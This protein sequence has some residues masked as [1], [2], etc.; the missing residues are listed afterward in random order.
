MVLDKQQT[1]LKTEPE[2]PPEPAVVVW[3]TESP[4]ES[5]LAFND[6]DDID[7]DIKDHILCEPEIDADN[8]RNFSESSNCSEHQEFGDA[9]ADEFLM[10]EK[11]KQTK[12]K[13]RQ[14]ANKVELPATS[15]RASRARSRELRRNAANA[16]PEEELVTIK[17]IPATTTATK[18]TF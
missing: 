12:G 14:I 18:I 6:D 10:S 1:L 16:S 3:N 4:L 9:F 8:T 5:K 2:P 17:T 7:N 15:L 11:S 13:T